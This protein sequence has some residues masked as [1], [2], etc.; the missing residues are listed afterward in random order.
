M[1]ESDSNSHATA[2]WDATADRYVE[3]VG[4]EISA[5]TEGPVDRALLAAFVDLLASRPGARVA[6][7]GCGPGRIASFLA[8]SGLLVLGI[9]P[10]TQ[11]L[12]RARLAH[13]TITFE[14]GRLDDLPIADASLLG[15]VCWYSIINTPPGGLDRCLVE[16]HRVLEPDGHLLL[17][18]QSGDGEAVV[19]SDAYGTGLPLTSY[20]HGVA[21][22]VRRMETAGFEWHATAE[23]AP[24]FAHETTQQA[25]VLARRREPNAVAGPRR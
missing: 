12:A 20:R 16:L 9:D 6:D 18:F 3:F 19:R 23:R 22:V 24:E 8:S 17:A 4:T 25:F 2:V 10:S 7:I 14:E 15:A 5:A 13:P 11:L 21:D 1:P